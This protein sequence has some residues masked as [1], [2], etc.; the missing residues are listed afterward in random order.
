MISSDYPR[1]A[2]Y[3]LCILLPDISIIGYLVNKRVGSITYNIVHNYALGL[4]LMLVGILSLHFLQIIGI[5][6]IIH[7]GLDRFFGF[8]LK[9]PKDFK[10]THIQR[11]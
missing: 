8:G 1:W 10:E 3:G 11:L 4:I 5:G 9:Y 6:I 2:W 7:V